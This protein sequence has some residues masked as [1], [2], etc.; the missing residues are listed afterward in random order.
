[1]HPRKNLVNLFKSFDK[2]KQADQR[3]IKLLIAGAK[4]WWTNEIREAYESMHFKEDVIFTGRVSDADLSRLMASALAL[5]YVSYFEG[6]GIPI[7]EAF[8]CGT[9]VI[10]STLTSM[11][12]VAGDA[13]LLVDPFS[14]DSIVS[15]MHFIADDAVLRNQLIV[16]GH[17]QQGLF[18]WNATAE[19]LW[20]TI[21]R[22]VS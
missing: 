11:P 4:M 13:A 10:T 12:E 2:F 15:S 8:H 20:N 18:S 6:F 22:T 7:L 1:M 5:T 16:K 14:V 3:G 21:E 17:K 19:K 9:P